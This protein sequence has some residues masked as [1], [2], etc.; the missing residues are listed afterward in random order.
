MLK[1]WVAKLGDLRKLQE[2]NNDSRQ[3]NNLF[4]VLF[5]NLQFTDHMKL[6]EIKTLIAY[7]A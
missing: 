5:P 7:I 6:K 1:A 2:A 4:K 3:A